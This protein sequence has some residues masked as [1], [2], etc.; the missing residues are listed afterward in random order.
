M[1][2]TSIPPE[3]KEY[4]EEIVSNEFNDS[5]NKNHKVYEHISINDNEYLYKQYQKELQLNQKLIN[6][7]NTLYV[8]LNKKHAQLK[9]DIQ[10]EISSLQLNRMEYTLYSSLLQKESISFLNRKRKKENELNKLYQYER[11][12]QNKYKQLI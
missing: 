1:A 6:K 5:D 2:Y 7:H 4:I 12:L 8:E 3:E 10:K 9:Q 11:K